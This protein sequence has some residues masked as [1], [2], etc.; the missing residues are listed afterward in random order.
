MSHLPLPVDVPVSSA[1]R[2]LFT[3]TGTSILWDT[4]IIQV[5]EL[6]DLC[7]VKRLQAL[8]FV[9]EAVV[10]VTTFEDTVF[11][12]T[13][14]STNAVW[15]RVWKRR[16]LMEWYDSERQVCEYAVRA[17]RVPGCSQIGDKLVVGDHGV[18]ARI[19][20]G[21]GRVFVEVIGNEC[22][23]S[24]WTIPNG[25][26]SRW[27]PLYREITWD[28]NIIARQLGFR[29]A[30]EEAEAIQKGA[31]QNDRS[32]E[33]D[34]ETLAYVFLSDS[35]V[36]RLRDSADVGGELEFHIEVFEIPSV[37]AGTGPAVAA[38]TLLT[39]TVFLLT[40]GTEPTQASLTTERR[41]SDPQ[42]LTIC[43]HNTGNSYVT[44]VDF[45]K[46]VDAVSTC[47]SMSEGESTPLACYS[48]LEMDGRTPDT[49]FV[50][51]TNKG[52]APT[53]AHNTLMF[54]ALDIDRTSAFPDVPLLRFMRFTEVGRPPKIINVQIKYLIHVDDLLG[55]F[56]GQTPYFAA[57]WVLSWDG[58]QTLCIVFRGT[59][60]R[61]LEEAR[62]SRVWYIRFSDEIKEELR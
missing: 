7:Q 26:E 52:L 18:H 23:A 4:T 58:E 40:A 27:M 24:F 37:A 20:A 9:G 14:V 11:I 42:F 48:S 44:I 2:T 43:I 59:G 61:S 28:P 31:V 22:V 32:D 3:A 19:S 51:H 17:Y 38:T 13:G 6:D 55:G 47:A 54:P 12:L 34:E 25:T 53:V 5:V 35:W 16:I 39:S 49:P 41:S 8:S 45:K 36:V 21:P 60:H 56:E 15:K 62:N 50:T 10:D 46:L 1:T 33:T 29:D 30:Q 57:P